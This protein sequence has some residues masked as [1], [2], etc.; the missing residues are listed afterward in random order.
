VDWRAFLLP[1]GE[2][3]F[4]GGIKSM[5]IDPF[6]PDEPLQDRFD[7]RNMPLHDQKIIMILGKGKEKAESKV[8]SH[9]MD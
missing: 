4:L 1:A 2:S 9:D 3:S 7:R 8:F 5:V 6:I